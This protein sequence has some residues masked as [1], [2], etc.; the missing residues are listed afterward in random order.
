MSASTESKTQTGTEVLNVITPGFVEEN[1]DVHGSLGQSAEWF[2]LNGVD[3]F[4]D[5]ADDIRN[6]EVLDN[7]DELIG[8][9]LVLLSWRFN[10]SKDRKDQ[11]TGEPLEFV[12]VMVQYVNGVGATVVAVINDG[13]TGIKRQLKKLT[14][15]REANGH[16]SPNAGRGVRRGLRKSEYLKDG[17]PA[18]TY[19]LDF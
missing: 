6:F 17:E 3:I 1:I 15:T 18:V 19:Y 11:E 2:Q 16:P 7:K 13:G 14:E 12:S 8:R 5:E 4:D 10:L 9:T